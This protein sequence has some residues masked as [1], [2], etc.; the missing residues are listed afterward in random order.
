MQV[1][2]AKVIA[3]DED[4]ATCD[5]DPA[6]GG[7]TMHDVRLRS[8]IDGIQ[9]GIIPI[10][11]IG[12]FILVGLI[13]NNINQTFVVSFTE[14]K[15]IT[16]K[17]DDIRLNGDQF[18]GL[19]KIEELYSAINRLEQKFNTHT[20]AYTSPSGTAI[21]PPPTLGSQITPLTTLNQLL[22]EQVKH[23]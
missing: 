23:G 10:P 6:D 18:N 4:N 13:N 5:C 22:N 17:C 7:P 21:T 12:S 11:E 1:I 16:I 8:S 20:H 2:A 9:E 14:L 3:I 15:K 19:G